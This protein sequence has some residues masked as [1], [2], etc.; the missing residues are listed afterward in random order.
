[1]R[2]YPPENMKRALDQANDPHC[3]L[4]LPAIA[5]ANSVKYPTLA[6]YVRAKRVDIPRLGRPPTMLPQLE[7]RMFEWFGDRHLACAP[8]PQSMADEKAREVLNRQNLQQGTSGEFRT[9]TGIPSQ[10]WWRGAK[11]RHPGFRF[12]KPSRSSA[13]TLRALNDPG[14]YRTFFD[15]ARPHLS[16]IP[17]A[18][19][20]CV[21]EMALVPHNKH[22]GSVW[23]VTGAGHCRALEAT[24]R[25]ANTTLVNAVLGDGTWL[26]TAVIL[27]GRKE[28]IECIQRSD[29]VLSLGYTRKRCW[30]PIWLTAVWQ[31]LVGRTRAHGSATCGGCVTA[32]TP[33]PTTRLRGSAT[34]TRPTSP[35]RLRTGASRTTSSWCCCLP[36]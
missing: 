27:G 1:M 34:S 18:R 3:R 20:V 35:R 30:F 25:K 10:S 8:I 4:S 36:T 22:K 5:R 17:E 31:L 9:P 19:R 11:S 7:D 26:P 13:A 15:K 24:G 33:R 28:N 6:G 23:M 21:D 2:L 32:L 14:K 29:T 16:E 12:G